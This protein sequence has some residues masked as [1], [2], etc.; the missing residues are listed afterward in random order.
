MSFLDRPSD[1][2]TD[3]DLRQDAVGH[4]DSDLGISVS[5]F[6]PSKKHQYQRS[7]WVEPATYKSSK[8]FPS[9]YAGR[10]NGLNTGL[11]MVQ[12]T[13]LYFSL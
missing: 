6:I 2:C 8:C 3:L 13:T 10:G 1:P 7:R 5:Q 9:D 12:K 4:S 11:I